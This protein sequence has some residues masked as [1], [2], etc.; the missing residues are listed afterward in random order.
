MTYTVHRD[1]SLAPILS[2]RDVLPQALRSIIDLRQ[3][4]SRES[5]RAF[6]LVVITHDEA[7]ATQLGTREYCE[8]LTRVWKDE[9]FHSRLKVENVQ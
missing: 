4:A 8:E 1:A 6:Q 5:E 7:F 3:S 9:D 2:L